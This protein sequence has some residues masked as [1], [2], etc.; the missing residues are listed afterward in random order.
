MPP[1]ALLVEVLY[2]LVIVAVTHLISVEML[3]LLHYEAGQAWRWEE[4]LASICVIIPGRI[5]GETLAN[6]EAFIDLT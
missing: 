5:D 3:L 6:Y 4:V 2:K 1:P